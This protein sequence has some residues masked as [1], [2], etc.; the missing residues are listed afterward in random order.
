MLPGTWKL[1]ELTIVGGARHPIPIPEDVTFE[2]RESPSP[3]RAKVSWVKSQRLEDGESFDFE[4]R[5]ETAPEGYNGGEIH[6]RFGLIKSDPQETHSAFDRLSFLSSVEGRAE[7]KNGQSTYQLSV[8]IIPSVGR[9]DISSFMS[10]GEWKLLEV[11]LRQRGVKEP[12][13][14]QDDVTFEARA[15][16]IVLQ[17]QAPGSVRAGHSFDLK[18]SLNG[19]PKNPYCIQTLSLDLRRRSPGGHPDPNDSH[20]VVNSVS[21]DPKEHSYEMSGSFASDL[22]GGPWQGEFTIANEPAPSMIDRITSPGICRGPNLEGDTRFAFEVEPAVGLVT[23]TSFTVT[24]N[25]S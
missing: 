22:P 11:T 17:V 2:V 4:V 16:S 9:M 14:L 15:P 18:V 12:V 6:Y 21:L 13:L 25:P 24:V 7:L 1:T 5:L 19:Y 23:P 20:V 3:I 10:L 8:P